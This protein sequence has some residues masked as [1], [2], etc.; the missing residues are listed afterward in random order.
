M[1]RNAKK[2]LIAAASLVVVGAVVSIAAMALC[3]WDFSSLST[4]QYETNTYEISEKFSRIKLNTKTADLLFAA[5]DD[6]TCRVVC[7]EE[8]DMKH[9][10]IV[11]DETL[12]VSVADNRKW[13]EHIGFGFYSPKVTVY[14]PKSE[15]ASLVIEESTGD[16]TLPKNFTFGSMELSL[17]TGHVDSCASALGLMRIAVSTGDICLHD[18]SAGELE[19]TVSTGGVEAQSVSCRNFDSVGTT[20]DVVL[21]N[22]L[23]EEMISVERSTGSVYLEEC[24]GGELEISTDTGDVIGSLKSSKVFIAH[25]DTGNVDVPETIS[26]G[27]CRITTDTGDIRMVVK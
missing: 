24:D 1:S 14:L 6:N 5:S 23:A 2:W 17:S 4:D 11:Q 19:L 8:P 13:H 21:K 18:L 15:Y 26:G 16:I 9:S 25:S 20:G 10:V 27:K 7:Y 12:T 22:V 3:H